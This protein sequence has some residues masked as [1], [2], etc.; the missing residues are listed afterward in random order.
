[1]ADRPL[2]ENNSQLSDYFII[3]QGADKNKGRPHPPVYTHMHITG[4][5]PQA[6]PVA[7]YK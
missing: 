4:V 1:M 2:K 5:F 7:L 3:L 6:A